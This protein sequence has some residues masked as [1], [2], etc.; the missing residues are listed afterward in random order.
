MEITAKLKA[1]AC[2]SVRLKRLQEF[3][4]TMNGLLL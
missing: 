3:F 1:A 4:E 2:L